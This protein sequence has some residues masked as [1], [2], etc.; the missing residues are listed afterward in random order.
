MVPGPDLLRAQVNEGI[1]EEL[2]LQFPNNPVSDILGIYE[3]LT[4]KALVKDSRIF[5]GRSISLV[6]AKPV[7]RK[8]A[9]QL[10]ETSLL[11][12]GYVL[13]E[14]KD[15]NSIRVMMKDSSQATL[16]EGIS[17]FKSPEQLP[18]GESLVSYF[19]RLQHMDPTEAAGIFRNHVGLNSYGRIT[20]VQ[21]PTGLLITE[22]TAIVRQLI[23]LQKVMDQP[24]KEETMTTRFIE[25]THAE[26]TVVA[27]IVQSAVNA[28]PNRPVRSG[29][30]L[31][32]GGSESMSISEAL[33]PPQV[34]ADDRLNR[35]MVVARPDDFVYITGLIA[36]FDQPLKAFEPYERALNYVFADEVLPVLVDVLQDTG[37]GSSTLPGGGSVTV[38]QAP[39]ASTPASTLTGRVRRGVQTRDTS[40]NDPGGRQDQLLDPADNGAPISVQVG[41]TRLIA[42][43]QANKILAT[44]PTENIKKISKIL[45]R[46]DRKPPQVY[47]ATVIGQLSLGDDIEYGVQYL[48]KFREIGEGGV[49]GGFLTQESLRSAVGDVREGLLTNALGATR[50]LNVYGQISDSL[51]VFV[52]ALETTNRFKVLSRPSIYAL[53]NKKA[54]IASGERIP[55]PTSTVTDL[56][57][58]DTFRTNIEFQDVVLKLEVIP[59][60][61][62]DKEVTLTIAQIND[63]VVREQ[64]VADNQIPVIGTERLTTT[65]TVPNEG[66]VVLGGLITESEDNT[67]SGIPVVSRIP[68]IGNAFRNTKK[69]KSRKELIIFI[70][71]VVVEDHDDLSRASY[72]EDIRTKVGGEAYHTFPPARGA[73]SSTYNEVE[74]AGGEDVTGKTPTAVSPPIDTAAGQGPLKKKRFKL[75][76]RRKP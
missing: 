75:F 41:K 63:T 21:S 12:N 48:Q 43:V 46:L 60:I 62:S 68:I 33:P 53:N 30:T 24:H 51:D 1:G 5:D 50:G 70:Q 35:I 44:G 25:L 58:T 37:T 27:A 71:P 38:R 76:R 69:G 55:I 17:L 66:T 2:V 42:D 49:A 13:S 11:V 8:E 22:S 54:V 67:T 4:G 14:S 15:G 65:V 47:L 19:L 36:E 10:I 40:A 34:V 28:R 7:K 16:S 56:E 29:R 18:E 32:S 26:A 59:L 45:D 74:P 31:T 9:I 64:Q 39:Q 3:L 61:N 6:T 52:N 57:D 72:G 23:G 20:P 73:D